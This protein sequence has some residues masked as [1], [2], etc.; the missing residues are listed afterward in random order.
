MR[1]LCLIGEM[2][3]ED[4]SIDRRAIPMRPH[5]GNRGG[6]RAIVQVCGWN[7]QQKPLAALVCWSGDDPRP[8]VFPSG[9]GE[10]NGVRSVSGRAGKRGKIDG[11][12]NDCTI[13][14]LITLGGDLGAVWRDSD[15]VG[16]GELVGHAAAAAFL[17]ARQKRD[18]CSVSSYL[19]TTTMENEPGSI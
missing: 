9:I 7:R 10:V 19:P 15:H 18:Y 2:N 3:F 4:V 1:L 5:A 6:I 11:K 16:G 13:H 14:Y 12:R 8:H 17:W